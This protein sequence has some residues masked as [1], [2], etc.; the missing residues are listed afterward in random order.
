MCSNLA[1]Q[2]GFGKTGLSWDQ[3][4]CISLTY[5]GDLS[6][7]FG[8]KVKDCDDMDPTTND[9][10]DKGTGE[11]IHEEVPLE[12]FDGNPC[13][14][15]LLG[16]DEVSGGGGACLHVPMDCDDLNTCTSDTCQPSTGKC[17]HAPVFCD[18]ANA[19]TADRCD[20]LVGCRHELEVDL[21]DV[22]DICAHNW[23]D[24]AT[25]EWHHDS[26]PSECADFDLCTEDS[27]DEVGSCVHTPLGC[28]D[29]N[30]CTLDICDPKYKK[31]GAYEGG[32]CHYQLAPECEP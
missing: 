19:C 24:P 9:W 15:D 6:V 13:T 29:G 8:T 14:W 4:A 22:K 25:G 20:V 12:C 30:P 23:C 3:G 18:D 10:C 26:I 27:V 1:V 5:L 31:K 21:K 7:P 2:P 11:C 32:L 16:G 28:D 17:V